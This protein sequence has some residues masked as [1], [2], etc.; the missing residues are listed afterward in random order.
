MHREELISLIAI[1]RTHGDDSQLTREICTG[2]GEVFSKRAV[3]P[4][5]GCPFHLS[6]S[7]TLSMVLSPEISTF[8][9][10]CHSLELLRPSSVPGS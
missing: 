3:N 9:L 10:L 4:G 5:T 2:H 6:S 8:Y 1:D 7:K